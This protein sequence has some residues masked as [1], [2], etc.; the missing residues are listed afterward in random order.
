M[1]LRNEPSDG[2]IVAFDL[3][4]NSE[5][6]WLSLGLPAGSTF[7]TSLEACATTGAIAARDAAVKVPAGAFENAV[8]VRYRGN[9]ADAGT[10]EQFFA[11]QVGLVITEE[12]SFAGPV[13]FELAYYRVGSATGG[14]Q[15]V[16]F[17]VA[18]DAPAYPRGSTLRA[19][20][21]LRSTGA[22]AIPLHFPSGQSFDL[23]IY[24]ENGAVVD[25]WSKDKLFAMIIRDEKFGPGE[26]TYDVTLPL[27]NLA[28]GRYYAEGYLAT[29]PVLYSGRVSF[30]VV[31]TREIMRAL[32]PARAQ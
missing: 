18:L 1:L 8:Q 21:T 25:T 2:S 6:P 3:G 15:E 22:E 12:T 23:K 4:S 32:K 24:D 30:E 14:A 17:T 26:K 20:L 10:T 16:A 11:P 31:P 5:K 19:R 13:K 7:P 29:S 9:C 28:P 27:P